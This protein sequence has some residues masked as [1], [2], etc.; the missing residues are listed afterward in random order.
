MN[1]DHGRETVVR[2]GR[3]RKPGGGN[4][5]SG[6]GPQGGETPRPSLGR[7]ANRIALT[8]EVRGFP[9]LNR[10]LTG[11]VTALKSTATPVEMAEESPSSA[12]NLA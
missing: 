8:G 10:R 3:P 9:R 4:P 11:V 1:C 2:T 7:K 6:V 12:T 5:T